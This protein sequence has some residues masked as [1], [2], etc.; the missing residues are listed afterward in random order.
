MEHPASAETRVAPHPW[1]WAGLYFPLGLA[2]GYP[3]VALGYLGSRSG[4][5]L[6]GVAAI[7]GMT[8]LGS[9][10]KFLWAPIGD[11][12]LT[13]KT[14]YVIA[15]SLVALGL[16]ALTVVP[17]SAATAGLLSALTL[18]TTVASVPRPTMKK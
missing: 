1:V 6:D 16:L 17:V 11:Y 4:L 18:L 2:I 7:V 15:V 12:T 8:F 14:W 10:W 3:S 5:T 9:G 13:R